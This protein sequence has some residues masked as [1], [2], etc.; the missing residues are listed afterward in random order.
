MTAIGTAIVDL[1]ASAAAL[2]SLAWLSVRSVRK[3]M[4]T[5]KAIARSGQQQ[6]GPSARLQVTRPGAG[7]PRRRNRQS[8]DVLP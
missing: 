1:G 3:G 7:P 2:G 8:P 4:E 5:D 6:G